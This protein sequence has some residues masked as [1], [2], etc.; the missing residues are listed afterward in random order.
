MLPALACS[1]APGGSRA[2]GPRRP[3]AAAPGRGPRHPLP[4]G[5]LRL[6]AAARPRR[7]AGGRAREDVRLPAG[8]ALPADPVRRQG[9]RSS[10]D[11]VS[12]YRNDGQWTDFYHAFV[13]GEGDWR[14]ATR[15]APSCAWCCSRTRSRTPTPRTGP[16]CRRAGTRARTR[17]ARRSSSSREMGIPLYVVLV[18]DPAGERGGPG[19]RAVARLRARPGAGRQRR[20]PRRR[21]PRPSPPSSRTTAL[22]LRKFVYR[23]APAR[24]PRRRSSRS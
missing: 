22:L 19:P 3:L 14:R 16:T 6:A 15:A 21:S 12:R 7:E 10:V 17:C 23:V 1:R 11:D 18:G 4:G 5:Q 8:P 13:Q 24:G 9:A 2:A 20:P